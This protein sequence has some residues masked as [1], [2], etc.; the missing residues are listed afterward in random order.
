MASF[1]MLLMERPCL[2][3]KDERARRKKIGIALLSGTFVLMGGMLAAGFPPA[4]RAISALPLFFGMGYLG[5]IPAQDNKLYRATSY[6]R[7]D[8]EQIRFP[9]IE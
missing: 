8:S 7:P 9:G 6:P 5:K 3:A 1:T 4:T 2:L